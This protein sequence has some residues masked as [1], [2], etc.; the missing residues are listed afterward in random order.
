MKFSYK[1]I[2]KYLPDLKSKEDLINSLTM[3]AF[4]TEDVGGDTFDVSVPSNRYSTASYH[5][6]VAKEAAAVMNL[7]N[8]KIPEIKFKEEKGEKEFSLEVKE[9]KLCPRYTAWYFE[10]IKIESSPKWIQEV[11]IDCGLRPINNVVDIMNY[12]MLETGQP[13]HAFDYDKLEGEKIV[14]RKAKRQEKIVSIEGIEYELDPSVLVIADEKDPLAIAGIKGGGKAEIKDDTKRI[15]VESANFDSIS[16]YN[17][18]RNINLSTDASLRF[19]HSLHKELAL[20]GLQR[21]G[22]LLEEIMGA[23]PGGKINS[24]LDIEPPKS[25]FFSFE[26]FN[27]FMGADF[28]EREIGNALKKLGF[29]IEEGKVRVPALRDDIWT[30][31]DLIEEAGRVMGFD[32]V[33]PR[34]PIINISSPE[35]D[36]VFVF[37]NRV[38]DIMASLGYDEVY[39]YSFVGSKTYGEIEIENPAS[40]D[41]AFL[42]STVKPLILRNIQ[43]NLKYCDKVRIFEVGRVFRKEEECDVIGIGF[44][45][46]EKPSLNNSEQETFF[47]VKGVVDSLLKRLGL[48]DFY[49]SED[50]DSLG[51]VIYADQTEIG[52][53]EKTENNATV[54][55]LK[56]D[57]L[58]DVVEG[59]L[60]FKPLPKFPAV[61]RDVSILV[62]KD[63]KIGN[64]IQEIQLADLKLI[65]DVDLIDEYLGAE[66]ERQSITLRIRFRAEDR[67]L[68]KEEVDSKMTKITSVLENKF[69]AVVR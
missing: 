25:I 12:V 38:R 17:T 24:N 43:E 42:R 4:E 7:K 27:S 59:E 21:A 28:E 66:K 11:L 29:E 68:S 31:E 58:M 20:T 33:E 55:E 35:T 50:G 37:R 14:V 47:E 1:L 2:K 3:R 39:N 63:E 67:T 8:I 16:I 60:S 54:A 64:V 56:S 10:N 18:S 49:M 48:T 5:I 57:I 52:R 26:R 51:L 61:L 19:S 9:E 36:N 15:I 22:E 34:S 32:E 45:S 23:K 69:G 46:N 62:K 6:G 65:E 41:K 40:E 30:E 53:I 13:L 44:G